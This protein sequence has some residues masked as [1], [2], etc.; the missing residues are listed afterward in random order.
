MLVQ[1]DREI[2]FGGFLC[3]FQLWVIWFFFLKEGPCSA[4]MQEKFKGLI[5][6]ECADNLETRRRAYV[7][8]MG[9]ETNNRV[10]GEGLGVKPYQ[11]PWI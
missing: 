5:E 10:R 4:E 7:E 8:T 9:L 3:S 6:D 2:K 11:V 1:I